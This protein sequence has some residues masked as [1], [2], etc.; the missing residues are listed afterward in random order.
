MQQNEVMM[1]LEMPVLSPEKASQ[2]RSLVM[3]CAYL[4]QDRADICETVEK[5]ARFMANPNRT[6]MGKAEEARKVSQRMCSSGARVRPTKDVR[7]NGLLHRRRLCGMSLLSQIDKRPNVHGWSTLH[8]G[9]FDIAE[10]HSP[11]FRRIRVLLGSQ[12]VSCSTRT[13]SA[14]QRM[15]HQSGMRGEDRFYSCQTNMQQTW[16][17]RQDPP[18]ANKVPLGSTESQQQGDQT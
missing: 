2:Y 16:L 4:S 3:R 14:L 17:E 15:E 8:P 12:S 6:L 10:Y 1:A 7:C 11:F 9:E 18:C 13:A 5:L